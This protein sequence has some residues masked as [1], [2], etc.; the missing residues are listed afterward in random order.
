MTN[1]EVD[2]N[3][4]QEILGDLESRL[5][6]YLVEWRRELGLRGMSEAGIDRL[7]RL[8]AT[9]GRENEVVEPPHLTRALLEKDE[10]F[11]ER[12]AQ[13]FSISAPTP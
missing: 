8:P 4:I 3:A 5:E 6:T 10:P 7:E 2:K 11:R 13:H 12:A 1:R 9:T